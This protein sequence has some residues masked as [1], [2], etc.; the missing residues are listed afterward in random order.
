MK[1]NLQ[2]RLRA[3]GAYARAAI[4]AAIV[5]LGAG[6]LAIGPA[7]ALSVDQT[8]NPVPRQGIDQQ[9]QTYRLTINYNDANIGAGQFFGA[10]PQGAYI[11]SIDAYV[12]TGFN[13]GTTN[14]ITIGTTKASA[15]EIVAS[16]ITAGTPGV[17]HLTS[18][19]GLGLA[20]TASSQITMYAKYAQTGTAASAGSVTIVIAY[21]PNNDL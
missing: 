17:Y 1:V 3:F 9:V 11:L 19:A 4:L 21:V 2:K 7:L 16:G 10:L 6:G 18:A 13:A 12:T 8:R 20:V 5:G 15:N 14:V